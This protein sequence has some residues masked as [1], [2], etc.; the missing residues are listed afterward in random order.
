GAADLVATPTS[1]RR[2]PPV[3]MSTD[4]TS[5][6]VHAL[7][8]GFN[9]Q[10]ITPDDDTY[11]QARTV[12]PGT[13]DR[14][15]A[16]IARPSDAT[17]VARVIAAAK[18]TGIPLAVRGG[19]HSNAG[20]GVCDGGLVLDLS[21]MKAIDIDV[22]GRTAWASAGLTAG[23]YTTAVGAHGLVTGFGDAGSVGLGGITL[24]GGIGFLVRKHGLTVDDLLAAELVTA[25]GEIL[26]VDAGHHPDLFWAIRGGGGNFG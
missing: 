4:H 21:A 7:G 17:Q 26:H 10:V 13:I 11:D 12:Y 25:D 18:E 14:R 19:G 15:P 24:G 20:H 1:P 5:A 16:V 6:L 3:T 9:G 23:E 8:T 2:S 22:E